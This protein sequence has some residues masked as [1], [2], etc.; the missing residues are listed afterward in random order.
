MERLSTGALAARFMPSDAKPS[1][2][3]S[4]AESTGVSARTRI[5]RGAARAFGRMGFGAT[6]VETILADAGV[7]RRTFY[8]HFRSKE[9]VLRVL[10]ES[11]VSMLI[12]AVRETEKLPGSASD[13]L[14]AAVEGYLRVHA[15]AGSLARVLL[16]E[17]FSPDSPLA[18]QR[19]AAMEAFRA[20]IA[21][22]IER[23]GRPAVDPILLHGVVAGIN[24]ITVQMAV[25]H[26]EGA[27]DI[28]RA[29]AAVLRLLAA[30]S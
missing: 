8:R 13:R 23:E 15:E 30:L 20:L 11:S 19:D 6:S 3:D 27:W 1:Q 29:N 7:S 24:Q 10:F 9:D 16:Q 5:L 14:D 4:G 21:R 17:Q 25:E 26:P 12:A 28:P 2:P 18:Q 22:G